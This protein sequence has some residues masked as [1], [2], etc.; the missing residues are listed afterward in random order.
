[1][2]DYGA[3]GSV[4]GYDVKGVVDYLLQFSS[5]WPLLKIGDTNTFSGTVTHSLGY[6]PFH[7]L[8]T[9][10]GRVDQLASNYGVDSSVLARAS[11]SGSPRY[12]ICRLSLTESFT[13]PIV[14][15]TTS[16]TAAVDS[17][18]FKVSKPGKDVSST[19]MRDFSLHSSTRSL[20]V[21]KVSEGAMSNTGGGLG[22]ERTVAHGLGYT[23]IA[24]A[25][26]RPDTN[27]IGLATD[28]YCIVPP[29]IGVAGFYYS[30]DSTNI[31]VTADSGLLTGS[32][33]SSIVVLKD[34]FAKDIINLSFP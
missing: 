12:F 1:M 14:S 9:S 28:R 4:K 7:F 5:S 18:G 20:M 17:H 33:R 34:P 27:S 30:V 10:D 8:A 15:G 21:H 31:Y 29:A 23:P 16:T 13:A 19:D 3:K 2:A 32:P 26:I 22:W 11:G 24:F 25:F 6:P